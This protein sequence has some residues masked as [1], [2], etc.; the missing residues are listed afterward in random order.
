M[1]WNP[2]KPQDG[3]LVHR[4]VTPS[5]EFA[6]THLYTLVK[7]GSVKVNFL[8]QEIGNAL[9]MRPPRLPQESS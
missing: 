3:M 1:V 9:F 4:R 5:T 6:G 8:A 2:R 7:R